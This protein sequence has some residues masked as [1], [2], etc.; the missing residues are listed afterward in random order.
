MVGSM[1]MSIFL[2]T[3]SEVNHP[4]PWD[5][6][7][8]KVCSLR[9]LTWNGYGRYLWENSAIGRAAAVC[10]GVGEATTNEKPCYMRA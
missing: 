3:V 9:Y 2:K 8:C 6:A 5:D 7:R 1:G 10:A 4:L